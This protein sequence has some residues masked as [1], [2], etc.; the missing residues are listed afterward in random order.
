MR[1]GKNNL[2][3]SYVTPTDRQLSGSKHDFTTIVKRHR[4]AE[5]VNRVQRSASKVAFTT[6]TQ[7]VADSELSDR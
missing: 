4:L 1:Q 3:I 5:S 6:E 7:S 2:D